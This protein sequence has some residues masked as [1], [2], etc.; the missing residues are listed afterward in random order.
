M[1]L[2]ILNV[3]EILRNKIKNNCKINNNGDAIYWAS[4]MLKF[5]LLLFS[6]RDSVN[7]VI[8]LLRFHTLV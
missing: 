5:Y 4:S 6:N 8:K 7:D 2:I 1:L 3:I